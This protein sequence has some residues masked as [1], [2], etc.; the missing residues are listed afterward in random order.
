MKIWEFFCS[1]FSYSDCRN[2]FVCYFF[3]VICRLPDLL[4]SLGKV[5]EHDYYY[6]DGENANRN[7]KSPG[8]Y[9]DL[10]M[11]QA[12]ILININLLYCLRLC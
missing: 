7:R 3:K 9:N 12:S 1:D 11:L 6:L 8:L 2:V 5:A 4:F 10:F